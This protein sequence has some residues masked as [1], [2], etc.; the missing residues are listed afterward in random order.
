VVR[1]ILNFLINIHFLP[2]ATSHQ[3]RAFST[4][5]Q[6]NIK[7]ITC[8]SDVLSYDKMS[9]HYSARFMQISTWWLASCGEVITAFNAFCMSN[10]NAYS[11]RK[12]STAPLTLQHT[13]SK[14]QLA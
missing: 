6:F 5:R 10:P 7:S 9:Q 13:H 1:N 12:S 3:Q 2:T 11:L 4:Q 14:P 8:R